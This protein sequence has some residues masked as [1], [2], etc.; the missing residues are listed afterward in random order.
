MGYN[1]ALFRWAFRSVPR[2]DLILLCS[3]LAELLLILGWLLKMHGPI[4]CNYRVKL[5]ANYVEELTCNEQVSPRDH[6]WS[7]IV[8]VGIEY[9]RP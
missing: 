9:K 1:T 2:G 5:K 6:S 8:Q 3:V 4:H 7:F